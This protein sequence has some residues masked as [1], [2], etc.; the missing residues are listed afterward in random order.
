MTRMFYA[1]PVLLFRARQPTP[2]HV[3]H[4]VNTAEKFMDDNTE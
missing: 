1:C 4:E 2:P 3:N